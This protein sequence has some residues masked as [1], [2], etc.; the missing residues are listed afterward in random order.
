[1]N[2][3]SVQ[4]VTR[5]QLSG[6]EL[7]SFRARLAE[8]Q[9]IAPGAALATLAPDPTVEEEPVREIDRLDAKHVG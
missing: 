9:T 3:S 1:V 6:K 8:L 2:P 5:A 7:A 4:F